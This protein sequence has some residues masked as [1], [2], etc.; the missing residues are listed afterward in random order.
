MATM[1]EE[2]G[3]KTLKAGSPPKPT[4]A[5]STL[6]PIRL[7]IIVVGLWLCL[8]VSALDTTIVTT[9]LIKISSDFGSLNESAWLIVTYLLTYNSFLLI[10]SK[11]SDVWG[12]KTV[13]LTCAFIFLVFSMACGGAQ[14]M[15]QLI[16]FRAFQGIGGSGMY[17]LT[18]VAIMK[19]ITPEKLGFYSGII[20]SVFVIANLLGPIL[21]GVIADDTTWRWIFFL[22]GPIIAVAFSALCLAMPGLADG[23]SHKERFK[24]FDILGGILS[25]VWPIPLL[26][27]LQ[28]GGSRWE[29]NSSIIIGTLT[30]GCV[31]FIVFIFYETWVT[32]R[33]AKD[34]VLNI[35]FFRKPSMALLLLGMFFLGFA[36]YIAII[37]LPQRFQ[38]VNGTSASRAGILLL[39]LTL[40]SPVGAMTA[41]FLMQKYIAAEYLIIIANVFIVVGIG[42]V[43]S[44]P[45]T[46]PFPD[47]TFGYEII[48][49]I[50]LG[51]SSPPYYFLLGT[52]IDRE[53]I[54]IGTG[55][56]NMLRTLGGT[57]G[58]AICSALLHNNLHT[59]L[60]TFLSPAETKALDESIASLVILSP[61]K[62]IRVGKIYGQSYNKQFQVMIA[63]AGANLLTSLALLWVRKREGIFNKMPEMEG[64]LARTKDV[65][66]GAERVATSEPKLREEEEKNGEK[67]EAIRP[68]AT[69]GDKQNSQGNTGST[70]E[71]KI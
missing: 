24:N 37:E 20:S 26:F 34:P 39:A 55:A 36:F 4:D 59:E 2:H 29:W 38:A 3:E 56:L 1:P 60:P 71:V 47:A 58:V 31:G 13:I 11:L 63:F 54:A 30:G 32:Y 44:L 62:R 8:F 61:D 64:D 22:N 28:E 25:I 65:E 6:S 9:A 52:S 66:G 21:G 14:T 45:A 41:G 7:N 51:L 23:K 17:S 57:I 5:A 10:T 48:L 43:S 12:I 33:T 53:D 18:F 69:D 15:N 35:T 16:V 68:S 46:H 27:A 49:G 19:L 42:L 40:L 67:S 50:G 70:K